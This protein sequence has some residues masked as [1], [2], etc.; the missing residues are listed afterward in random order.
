MLSTFK[1]NNFEFPLKINVKGKS[2]LISM[3]IPNNYTNITP[4]T[5][6]LNTLTNGRIFECAL[7]IIP[8]WNKDKRIVDLHTKLNSTISL[9]IHKFFILP[10][11]F[12]ISLNSI[13][14][15]MLKGLGKAVL[16]HTL[17]LL[18]LDETSNIL[19]KVDP[20]IGY[21]ERF[22]SSTSR[23]YHHMYKTLSVDRMREYLIYSLHY[24]PIKANLIEDHMLLETIIK[25]E[26]IQSLSEYYTI[27]LGFRN[28]NTKLMYINYKTFKLLHM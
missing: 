7:R 25:L 15:G 14:E 11:Y 28:Y 23:S 3:L 1:H 9:Y 4:M 26:M 2:V 8:K 5:V 17:Q 22:I 24:N 18:K 12:G 6:S 20:K 27:Q 19:L 10:K 21:K 13:E 16:I